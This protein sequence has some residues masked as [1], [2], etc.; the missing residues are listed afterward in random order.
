MMTLSI[1]QPAKCVRLLL[2][3]T[4]FTNKKDKGNFIPF[5]SSLVLH[6]QI[7]SK[8]N[9]IPGFFSCFEQLAG[10]PLF[11]EMGK[12]FFRRGKHECLNISETHAPQSSPCLQMVSC[13]SI[14]I[15]LPAAVLLSHNIEFLGNFLLERNEGSSAS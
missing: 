5:H 6:I 14:L 7:S 10:P 12:L 8:Q 2:P 11:P 4:H 1:V 13:I 3:F 15:K 9:R